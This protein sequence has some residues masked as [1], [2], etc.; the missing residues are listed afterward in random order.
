MPQHNFHLG[1][2]VSEILLRSWIFAVAH[3][4]STEKDEWRRLARHKRGDSIGLQT[5][6]E[7]HGE[8]VALTL[9]PCECERSL[10]MAAPVAY[11][12]SSR[13]RKLDDAQNGP[14][15]RNTSGNRQR[16]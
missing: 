15:A 10:D 5:A 7:A 4:T 13:G 12:L 1:G 9:S 6:C 16:F 3:L 8:E 2:W 11:V 14:E